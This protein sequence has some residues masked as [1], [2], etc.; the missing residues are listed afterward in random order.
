MNQLGAV[1]WNRI[2]SDE[3]DAEG[4]KV[5]TPTHTWKQPSTTHQFFFFNRNASASLEVSNG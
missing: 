5:L 3:L 1:Y 4:N 2:E